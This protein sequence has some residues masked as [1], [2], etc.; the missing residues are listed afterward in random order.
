MN[1]FFLSKQAIEQSKSV[2]KGFPLKHY[3]TA[4]CQNTF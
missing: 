2:G 4:R 3:V 1:G